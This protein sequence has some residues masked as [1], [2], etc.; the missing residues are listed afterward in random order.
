MRSLPKKM[1]KRI[2]F[3]K[4]KGAG[5]LLLGALLL[6]WAGATY[7]VEHFGLEMFYT[8]LFCLVTVPPLFTR[9]FRR[10][11]TVISWCGM[12]LCLWITW[13]GAGDLPTALL[14]W[15]LC[16]CIPISLSFVWPLHGTVKELARRAL[17]VA[18]AIAMAGTVLYSKLHFGS[19]GFGPMMERI[20]LRIQWLMLAFEEM[21]PQMYASKVADEYLKMFQAM[22]QSPQQMHIFALYTVLVVMYGLF[23]LFF[24][25]IFR[26]D[27]K[28]GK[29]GLG[30]TLGSWHT[31]I[32]GRGVSW[33]FMGC[34]LVMLL[35]SGTFAQNMIVALDL[36]GFLY[37]FTA[38]YYLLQLLRKKGLPPLLC[39]IIVGALFVLSF[40]T[41]GGSVFSPYVLL[42][43]IG[44]WI[45]TTPFKV[46]VQRR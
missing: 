12:A 7:R 30:R 1:T 23:G 6:L 22:R 40:F 19:W 5:N 21:I 17:P 24:W 38:L 29:D 41:V 43:Y 42:M 8:L 18:G 34:Y 44:W 31:L 46:T 10:L 28:A 36:F 35:I 15:S 26:A 39:G 33:L 14:V 4:I 27:R 3:A 9:A 16:C 20:T 11:G 37:V 25:C 45:A 2:F 13:L 32:P